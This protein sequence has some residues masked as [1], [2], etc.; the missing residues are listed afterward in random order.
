M[1]KKKNIKAQTPDLPYDDAQVQQVLEQYHQIANKL[2]TSTDQQQAESALN[3]INTLSEGT[4]IALLKALAKE[5]HVDA[6][7]VLT[8]LHE[9]SPIKDVRKEA[10]R[11]LI[12]LQEARIYPQWK[13]PVQSPLAIQLPGTPPRFWKGVVTDSRDIGEVNLLLCFE[14]ANGEIRVLGFLLEFWHDGVKDFFTQ[15]DSKRGIDNLLAETTTMMSGVKTKPCS[16]AE[17]RRLLR[18]AL[19]VNEKHGTV[20]SRDYRNNLPLIKRLVLES[21]ELGEEEEEEAEHEE[22]RELNID[23]KELSPEGVVIN[24]VETW[25]KGDYDIAYRLLSNESPVRN[26]LSMAEWV[27]RRKAWADEADPEGLEPNF[28][29]ER[30]IQQSGLWLPNPFVAKRSASHKE[31]DVGWSIEMDETELDDTLPELPKATAVYDETGRHWFWTSYALVQEEDA[32]RIQNITDEGTSAQNLPIAELRKRIQD[33]DAQ[34]DE[35]AKK[36]KPNDPDIMQYVGAITWHVMAAVYYSDVLMKKMPLDRT[37][38]EGAAS[39]TLTLQQ[40]ERAIVYL[41]AL[42]ERFTEQRATSLRALGI[43][44][45]QLSQKYFDEGDDERGERCLELAA[46]ALREALTLEDNFDTHISLAEV[47]IDE[48]EHLDEAEEHLLQAKTLTTNPADDAHIELHLGQIA[49]EREQYE[50]ALRHYQRVVDFDPN[51]A[52][53]WMEMAEAHKQLENFAEADTCYRRAISLEPDNDDYY[54]ALSRMYSENGQFDKAVEAIEEG[55]SANPDSAVLNIYLASLYMENGD[56][57]QAEIF[58]DRAERIDP[59]LELVQMFRQVLD[60]SKPRQ[61]SNVT[62]LSRPDKKKKRR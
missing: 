54:Y 13:P 1:A 33:H 37:V 2:H 6:A 25:A 20:P 34:L 3:E 55:I 8:A 46:E 52:E 29:H 16:L 17:G 59:E 21:P 43:A 27:E 45:R 36:H 7:D 62:R 56:Y 57:R 18:E 50:E 58:L 9:L 19:A 5:Q 38:Y 35:I 51:D 23:L 15:I 47:L 61:A 41:N 14:Q 4:Q 26:G 60:L 44:Q 40:Y 11:S 30:E 53:T 32:W 10:R 12:R 31:F 42:T 22:Y 28:I 39:R 49:M 48:N 24:F